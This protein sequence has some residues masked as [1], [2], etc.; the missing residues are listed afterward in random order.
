MLGCMADHAL[1]D[2]RQSEGDIPNANKFVPLHRI[3]PTI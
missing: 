1:A 2:F 3:H